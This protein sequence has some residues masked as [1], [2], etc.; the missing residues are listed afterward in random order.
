MCEG[1]KMAQS[2]AAMDYRTLAGTTVA[3]LSPPDVLDRI[4]SLINDPNAGAGE[5]AEVI[6]CDP[7]LTGQVLRMAN[8]GRLEESSGIDSVAD[9]VKSIGIDELHGIIFA[10][11]AN[12]VFSEISED[13]VSIEEFWHHSVCCGLAA[14]VLARRCGLENPR[15]LFAAGLLHDIGQLPIYDALPEHA[16]RVLKTAGKA[17]QYR[18]RAEKEII[19]FTHAQVGAEIMRH[20]Q[21]P[22]KLREPVEFHHEPRR[23]ERFPLE[24]AIVHIATNVANVIEP[25]WKTSGDL[26]KSVRVIDPYVW[27][28][29]G[30]SEDEMEPVVNDVVMLSFDVT[31]IV[32][33]SAMTI[34]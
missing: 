18:Y 17:E 9:A 6:A 30:L 11:T 33:P 5:L 21:F 19:G 32:T 22:E 16:H 2:S 3:L 25:S 7:G 15:R 12:D 23:A 13:L 4:R 14:D 31:A 27:R 24:T 10:S 20:W 26:E 28:V 29:T 8:N 34:F 1:G